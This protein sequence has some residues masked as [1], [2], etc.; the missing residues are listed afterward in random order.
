MAMLQR[1]VSLILLPHLKWG[2]GRGG[3]EYEVASVETYSTI[4]GPNVSHPAG[5]TRC[6]ENS[7]MP[8]T[9]LVET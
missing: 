5:T 8:L 2:R 3:S 9:S 4:V 7:D 1:F 6:L